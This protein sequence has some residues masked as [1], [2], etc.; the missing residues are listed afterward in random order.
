MYLIFRVLNQNP[1]KQAKQILIDLFNFGFLVRSQETYPENMN[2]NKP[3]RKSG[4][5]TPAAIYANAG[6]FTAN[7]EGIALDLA[8][9]VL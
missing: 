5:V 2:I 8:P 4:L 6:T 1:I 7:G 3:Y 9:K